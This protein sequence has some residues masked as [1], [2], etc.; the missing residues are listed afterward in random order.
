MTKTEQV[1]D[2]WQDVRNGLIKEVELIPAEQM[3]FKPASES[4]SVIE[5]LQHIVESQRVLAGEMCRDNTNFQRGFPA[6]MA[7]FA[8][9]VKDAT[10][11][12][13]LI[14]LLRSSMEE[15]KKN[16]LG[17]G[18]TGFEKMMTRFDG[19]QCTKLTMLNFTVSHEMYHRG[20]LTVYERL[21]GIEPALTQF[22]RKMMSANS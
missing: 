13:A 8:G 10:T 17:F 1:V 11:K 14:E 20:Q 21:L 4:R 3:S 9:G 12:D 2:Q 7:E 18:D 16:V 22:F 5:L 19:K 6:M 15:T